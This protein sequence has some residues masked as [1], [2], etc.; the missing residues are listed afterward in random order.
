M[1]SLAAIRGRIESYS[2]RRLTIERGF[3]LGLSVVVVAL[4]IGL[5]RTVLRC[6]AS[7]GV[8]TLAERFSLDRSGSQIENSSILDPTIVH[9]ITHE[10]ASLRKFY[11]VI[12]P[13]L[14]S[15]QRYR[16][17]AE[18][19]RIR[20][21]TLANKLSKSRSGVL[22]ICPYSEPYDEEL[23]SKYNIYENTTSPAVLFIIHVERMA[24]P[25]STTGH[26]IPSSSWANTCIPI[27][28]PLPSHYAI[29]PH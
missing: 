24:S 25:P 17:H 23:D 29:F 28:K 3:G 21:A 16:S 2:D 20:I 10:S 7:S 15:A 12:E 26:R 27:C 5:F 8:G 13:G 18:A 4:P 11:W 22:R 6:G 14:P 9:H 19:A 1:G